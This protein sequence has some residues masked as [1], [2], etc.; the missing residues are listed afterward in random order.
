MGRRLLIGLLTYRGPPI[1][2]TS[3]SLHVPSC[4]TQKK[5]SMEAYPASNIQPQRTAAYTD[6]QAMTCLI[7]PFSFSYDV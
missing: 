1:G 5:A 4:Q 3:V 2:D 6:N 7:P